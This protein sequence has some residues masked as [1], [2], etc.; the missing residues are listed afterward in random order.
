MAD[1]ECVAFL[2]EALPHLGLRWQGFRKVHGQVCKRL[3]R[4][5]NEL[6]IEGFAAYRK[7]LDTHPEEWAVLDGLTHIT[8]SR[9][10]RDKSIFE[11][12][13]RRV[14]PDIAARAEAEKRQ[15]RFW[16]AGC[17]SGEEP[18]TLKIL[19]DLAVAPAF[20][21]V[22]CSVVATDVDETVLK[23]AR[24]GCYSKGSLRELPEALLRQGFE[25]SGGFFCVRQQHREGVSFVFRTCVQKRRRLFDLILCRNVAFTYFAPPLQVEALDRILALLAKPGYLVIGAREKLPREMSFLMS[26]PRTVGDFQIWDGAAGGLGRRIPTALPLVPEG[27]LPILV[28][29]R[30]TASSVSEE[31]RR[32][33]ALVVE[34][35]QG[36]RDRN[37]HPCHIPAF[38]RLDLGGEL[39]V[40]RR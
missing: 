25:Q 30:V 21:G 24:N 5:M 10:F 40:W 1:A 3:S 8:I 26:F 20:P 38:P 13:E 9:F 36:R 2:Q 12:L 7:R 22:K 18:Y 39:H 4:R 14:L 16:S 27:R 11:A 19:W 29:V 37:P 33:N 35:R 32:C 17:A 28:F 34:Y 6:G 23:R 31:A 15:A